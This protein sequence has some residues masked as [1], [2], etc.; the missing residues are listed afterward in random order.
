MPR[1]KPHTQHGGYVRA[2]APPRPEIRPLAVMVREGA[3]LKQLRM[4]PDVRWP[5]KHHGQ[6]FRL[7]DLPP[8]VRKKIYAYWLVVEDGIELC[9]EPFAFRPNQNSNI[10][11]RDD[12]ERRPDGVKHERAE[13]LHLK[14]RSEIIGEGVLILRLSKKL[15]YECESL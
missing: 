4:H 12:G 11:V 1:G 7:M 10:I 5:N 13:V 9:P 8:E 15:H 2:D 6:A 3:T 14:H